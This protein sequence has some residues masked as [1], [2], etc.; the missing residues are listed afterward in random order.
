MLETLVAGVSPQYRERLV[1]E[2]TLWRNRDPQEVI[3]AAALADNLSPGIA[4]GRPLRLISGLDIDTKFVERN[5]TLLTRLL[6]ARYDGAASEQGLHDFL[7][8]AIEK[9]HWL[10]VAPLGT[11]LLPFRRQRVTAQELAQTRLPGSRALVVENEQCLHLLPELPGTV[12]ILG[13]GLDLQWLEADTFKDKQIAYWGDMDTWGLLMLGRARLY[14]SDLI[15]LMMTREHFEQY[16]HGCAVPEPTPAPQ[17]PPAGLHD[18]E[19]TFFEFLLE[20]EKGRL[21]QEYLPEGLVHRE[22]KNWMNR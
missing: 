4:Q 21:E 18:H 17:Q 2:R 20:Q 12:A 14:R 1:R 22:L 6:D 10:L 19:H 11:G 8:A 16:S 7:D 15:P 3:A 9:D 5:A 13:A